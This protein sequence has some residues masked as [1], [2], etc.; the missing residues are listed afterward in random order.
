[1]CLSD[2][3]CYRPPKLQRLL[4]ANLLRMKLQLNRGDT[5]P[6][7]ETPEEEK[8]STFHSRPT[9]ILIKFDQESPLK[10]VFKHFCSEKCH[11]DFYAS[12]TNLY[13]HNESINSFEA[14]DLHFNW[15]AMPFSKCN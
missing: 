2:A 6:S 14:L 1:M 8:T 4:Q 12:A 11:F 7:H 10:P 3:F 9:F 15:N 13:F 5:S